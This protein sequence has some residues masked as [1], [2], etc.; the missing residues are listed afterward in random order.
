[1]AVGRLR[2]AARICARSRPSAGWKNLPVPTA[3]KRMMAAMA[4]LFCDSFDQVPRHILLDIDDTKDRVHGGQQLVLWNAHYESRC[5]LPILP[6][7][8]KA[9]YAKVYCA[10]G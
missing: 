7:L 4:E 2:R 8:P 6:G 1:M 10:R 3:L 9:L 5:F